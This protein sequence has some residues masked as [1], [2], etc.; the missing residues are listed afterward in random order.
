MEA[1]AFADTST[2]LFAAMAAGRFTRSWPR[3][4]AAAF[5]FGHSLELFFKAVLAQAKQPIPRTHD[6]QTLYMSFQKLCSGPEFAFS[7]PIAEF[8]DANKLKP[9]YLFLKYPEDE[10]DIAK[11]WDAS[12]HIDIVSWHRQIEQYAREIPRIWSAVKQHYT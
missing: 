8:I 10:T 9:F 12:I 7:A 2:E 6:L 3:A 1:Q 11:R 4:K 5:A